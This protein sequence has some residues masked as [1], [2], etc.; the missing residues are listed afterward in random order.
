M[1]V[2]AFSSDTVL[3][4]SDSFDSEQSSGSAAPRARPARRRALRDGP[5]VRS[6][7]LSLATVE[8]DWRWTRHSKVESR[9]RETQ[10]R[11]GKKGTSQRSSSTGYSRCH[12]PGRSGSLSISRSQASPSLFCMSPMST[13]SGSRLSKGVQGSYCCETSRA[14]AHATSERR[15][16]SS[17]LVT[18]CATCCARK[19]TAEL[20]AVSSVRV[21]G[22][23][24]ACPTSKRPPS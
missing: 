14:V 13:A 16:P 9:S 5:A 17:T 23:G 8:M 7:P 12:G 6:P 19:T 2:C 3:S 15:V 10:K 1:S 24:G 18:R 21:A 4:S 11:G 22:S 20:A